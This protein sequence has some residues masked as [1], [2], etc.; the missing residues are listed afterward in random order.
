MITSKENVVYNARIVNPVDSKENIPAKATVNL[1]Q[2]LV[3]AKNTGM[4]LTIL[5]FSVPMDNVPILEFVPGLWKIAM[6]YG[7]NEIIEEVKFISWQNPGDV[8]DEEHY[9][10]FN[11]QQIC[12]M[13]NTT[14]RTLYYRIAA[15]LP[16]FTPPFAPWL[17]F[18]NQQDVFTLLGPPTYW[19]SSALTA[20]TS[21]KLLFNN[22]LWN[23]FQNFYRQI[24][25]EPSSTFN[26]NGTET[27]YWKHRS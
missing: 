1:N 17:I 15:E 4:K 9:H 26:P 3:D 25:V 24:E 10:I 20:A 21:G 2:P 11:Y 16:G 18:E 5:R 13:I 12:D 7:G 23:I 27:W 14:L 8:K 19:S 22:P 6:T